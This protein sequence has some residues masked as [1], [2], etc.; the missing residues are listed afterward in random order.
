MGDE[1]APPLSMA[2]MAYRIGDYDTYIFVRE[3]V[4]HYVKQVGTPYFRR[5]QPWH[6]MEF[7]PEE[8]YLTNM[9]DDLAGWQIDG[10]AYPGET[11]E[12]QYNN[13]WVRFSSEEVARFYRDV[14][15]SQVRAEMD[16][17]TRRARIK[18][19]SYQ[20]GEDTAHIAPSLIRLRSLLLNE[21]P[22]KLASLAPPETWR[23]GRSA[24]GTAFCL[25]F[26]RTSVPIQ[27]TRLIPPQSGWDA[28]LSPVE[29]WPDR[30]A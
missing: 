25:S 6:S 21:P 17:L 5:F 14:L 23:L 18:E 8:V 12:R 13:R 29:L 19:T 4:H 28:R 11:G 1:A 2:R 7:M 20:I 16:L 24:D 30:C 15:P 22:K 27:T 9:W 26:L 10:P 3:P